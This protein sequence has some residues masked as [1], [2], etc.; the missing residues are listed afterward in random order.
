MTA[1]ASA[2]PAGAA[3]W[4]ARILGML[5][6][7]HDGEVVAAG[8]AA[9]RLLQLHGV[10]WSDVLVSAAPEPPAAPAPSRA[11]EPVDLAA[12]CAEALA[13]GVLWSKVER[14]FLTNLPNFASPSEKQRAWF[15]KLYAMVAA[16]DRRAE[17][18][19]DRRAG[20]PGP[21]GRRDRGDA[22]AARCRRVTGLQPG[23]A[24]QAHAISSTCRALA[25]AARR[26]L[27]PDHR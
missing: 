19:A 7:A 27:Q 18:R 10:G 17:A 15:S 14:D 21:E 6:S 24:V 9:V 8:R 23:P 2:L 16:R 1:A 5:G 12:A 22:E 3:G 13:S 25:P 11:A 20:G 4:L 26:C